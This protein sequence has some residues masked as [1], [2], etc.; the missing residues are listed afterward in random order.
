MHIHLLKHT[1][2]PDRLVALAA[3]RCYSSLP[4]AAIDQ[5]LS[6]AEVDRLLGLLRL[7][8]H[9]SPFEHVSF[10][11]SV[12]GVSRAL[13]HQLVR[14]RIA[15]YSQ[16][17]Q[18]YVEY[19]KL[20]RL[21]YVVPPSIRDRPEAEAEFTSATEHALAAYRRLLALGVPPEDARY[22]FPNAV[23]TKL[24]F[25][26]NARSLFNFFE[27]RCCQKAQWEIRH[28]AHQMLAAVRAVAP[29]IFQTAG[30]PCGYERPYCRENDPACP[31]FPAA[32]ST[33]TNRSSGVDHE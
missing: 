5:K 12:D 31:R 33:P 9:L 29:R 11:F 3:R 17:S 25:T 22:V 4:A 16:E 23:E 32:L 21:P 20:D 19:L 8:N 30:A 6:E 10:T 7:R 15:S 2:D 28:L 14:H 27:Q 18:R 26:L 24:I 13:S 1:P